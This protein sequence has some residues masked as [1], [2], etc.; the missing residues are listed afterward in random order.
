MRGGPKNAA[1]HKARRVDATKLLVD[2]AQ[3]RH[4]STLETPNLVSVA[5]LAL[6]AAA[7]STGFATSGCTGCG[8][9]PPPNGKKVPEAP[10]TFPP[11]FE[12][13]GTEGMLVDPTDP[14]AI[15]T[16]RLGVRS[17]A[18]AGIAAQLEVSGK[19]YAS[20]GDGVIDVPGLGVSDSIVGTVVAAGH[21]PATVLISFARA[22]G[23][24]LIVNLAKVDVQTTFAATAG[25]VTPVG[26]GR[27]EVPPGSLVSR[28][29]SNGA[30]Y[31][32]EATVTASDADL[33]GLLS[34]PLERIS[35]SVS[36]PSPRSYALRDAENTPKPAV[37]VSA[38]SVDLRDDQGAPLAAAPATPLAVELPIATALWGFTRRNP[39]SRST[40]TIQKPTNT[41][42]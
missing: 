17:H 5:R 4:L 40:A 14:S 38:L 23:Q 26:K 22:G 42:R 3:A 16:A 19:T 39:R 30:P 10:P 31:S 32:G 9:E 18:G 15:Y 33:H 34:Q 8:G 7:G 36:L 11:A 28:S 20:G 6:L 37:M 2:D 12:V 27:L 24:P 21:Q 29:R 41:R 13:K 35:R 25:I 1:G